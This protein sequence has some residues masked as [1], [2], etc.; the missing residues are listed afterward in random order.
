MGR[1]DPIAV[2]L[3]PSARRHRRSASRIRRA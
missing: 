3:E 2:P 1:P